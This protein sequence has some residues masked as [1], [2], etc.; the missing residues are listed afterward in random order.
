MQ[1]PP[2]TPR[3]TTSRPGSFAIPRAAIEALIEAQADAVTIGAYLTLACHTD[4]SG[5]CST[6]GLK[7]IRENL[8]INRGR[9]EKAIHALCTIR[10]TAT[11]PKLTAP[12]VT[13]ASPSRSQSKRTRVPATAPTLPLVS[14]RDAWLKEQGGEL[15]DGPLARYPVRHILSMFDEPLAQRVWMGSGLVQGD[16]AIRKP[17]KAL[18]D[19]GDVAAR[20]LLAMYAGQDL[21]RWYGVP[22]QGFFWHYYTPT[23]SNHGQFR[24]LCASAP[25]PVGNH[26]LFTRIDAGYNAQK[27]NHAKCFE[28]LHALES[29]GLI[30]QAVVLLNRNPIPATCSPGAA[31]GEIAPDAELLCDLG[32]PSPFGPVSAIEQGLGTA[33]VDTV[34]QLAKQQGYP[35]A[36]GYLQALCKGGGR[37]DAFALI[38]TGHPAM[39]AGLYRLR[40]RVTHA[41]NAFI[42]DATR[43]HLDAH[44][45]ALRKL[46]YLRATKQLEPVTRTLQSSSIFL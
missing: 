14:T 7:A 8:A 24:I 2:I 16:P 6:G 12:E 40:F 43:R 3:V 35:D 21:D 41:K 34:N 39:I 27:K 19:C 33:Y 15:P 46:N 32:S 36:Q 5:A 18:R 31:Y 25:I 26:R 28:A 45:D 23:A 1:D 9:A 11:A 29:A 17:L 37:Y 38:L 30:Y 42:E 20:L 22:P 10:G 4:T 13:P 44:A